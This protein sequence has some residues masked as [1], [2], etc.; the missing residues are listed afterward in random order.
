M[1]AAITGIV[2]YLLIMISAEEAKI[3]F[4]LG[5]ILSVTLLPV[6]LLRR[7]AKEVAIVACVM[8]YFFALTKDFILGKINAY[9]DTLFTYDYLLLVLNQWVNSGL[10][11]GWNPYMNAGEPLY[12]ISNYF[13]WAPWVFFCW[14]N[15]FININPQILFNLYW[16]FQ[17]VNFCSGCLLLFLV[18]YDD[19]KAA[20]FCFIT[21]ILSG[22]FIVSLGQSM[23]ITI[24]YYL[25]YIIL[26]LILTFKRKNIYGA[27]LA[28]IYFSI[29][30]NHYLIHYIALC[31][32]IFIFFFLVYNPGLLA[33]IRKLLKTQYKAFLL[34]LAVSVFIALPA[35]FSYF[36]M[37]NYISPTRGGTAS[38][39]A[40]NM[41][42]TG[43]QS[44]VNAPLWGYRV[45]LDQV[46]RYRE[47]IHHAFYFGI[48]PLLFIPLAFLRL[49][50]RYFLTIF[51]SAIVILFLSTGYDFWGYRLLTRYVPGFNMIRHSFGLAHFVAFFLI[52]LSGYGLKELL[53]EDTA[54]ARNRKSAILIFVSSAA[55]F[56]ISRK[57]NV[58]VFGFVGATAI[59]FIIIVKKIFSEEKH[60]LIAKLFYFLILSILVSDLTLFYAF[61]YKTRSY[62]NIPYHLA[63]MRYP[64]KRGFYPLV[65]YPLPPDISPLI[66]KEAS[67]THPDGNY[68]F[69]RN[70]RINDMLYTFYPFGNY[71]KAL[72]V[73]SGTAYLTENIKIIPETASKEEVIRSIYDDSVEN[74]EITDRSVFLFKKDLKGSY[75]SSGN[76]ITKSIIEYR[77]LDNPNILEM[78]V[79]APCDI[80]LVRLEN[81]HP[82]WKAFIDGKKARIYRAN[83]AFQAVRIPEGRHYVAFKFSSIYP[84]LFYIHIIGVF[85]VWLAF[86][87]YIYSLKLQEAC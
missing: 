60:A 34:A 1:Q 84:A 87:F 65:S 26:C 52:C 71:W 48:I 64:V 62:K 83:Y 74:E 24:I 20:L 58:I 46:I 57:T 76:N 12:L 2:Q 47:N 72:G 85:I 27:A 13:L 33:L 56:L 29:A 40:I 66:F 38:G 4:Y 50:D 28:V 14:L 78:S 17:F 43:A 30:L 63:D 77:K 16:V 73:D 31:S 69:F 82:S 41:N 7:K 9:H 23:G 70:Q 35:L 19:F 44:N 22:M 55:M 6:Y 80:F 11:I 36:E 37:S 15:K 67:L 81:F 3:I 42:Q 51:S 49:R 45:L 68:V 18:L 54:I 61:N 39:V 5:L 59:L 53:R 10:S 32:G 8:A 86:N 79:D 21:L 25:P 75:F